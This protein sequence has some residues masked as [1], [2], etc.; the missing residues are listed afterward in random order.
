MTT[1]IVSSIRNL[2]ITNDGNTLISIT[3][4]GKIN[5]WKTSDH[6]NISHFNLNLNG[7][8][9]ESVYYFSKINQETKKLNSFLLLG[10]DDGGI[11]QFNFNTKDK[12][13]RYQTIKNPIIFQSY[14][15]ENKILLILTSEQIFVKLKI[16]LFNETINNS[17]AD[18]I[19]PGY[20][21]EFLDVKLLINKNDNLENFGKK[22]V[23]S[24]NDNYLKYF[25]LENNKISLFEGHKD[26]IMNIDIKDNL[27]A[28]CSKDGSVRLWQFYFEEKEFN[29]KNTYIFKGHTEIVN[30]LS[31]SVR[32][33]LIVSAGKDLSIKLWKFEAKEDSE[34]FDANFKPTTIKI[35]Y[36]SEMGHEEE[37]SVVRFSPNEKLIATGGYDKI[38]KV[39]LT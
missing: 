39:H 26:F 25:D 14:N 22:L 29:C 15:T 10:C 30:S 37:I 13:H 24:S 12:H 38:I 34:V 7:V 8:F 4:D 20:C 33:N 32:N 16:D 5:L 2:T 21:Q 11:L 6:T 28:T 36:L 31:L 9:I 18:S 23:F 19:L 3:R 1:E 17:I 27:I 35:S